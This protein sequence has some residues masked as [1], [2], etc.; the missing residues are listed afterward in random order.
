MAILAAV[1]LAA[2]LP[3]RGATLTTLVEFNGS[4][5]APKGSHPHG[6]LVLGLDGHFYG[7]TAGGGRNQVGT[8]F[9]MS[10][11]GVVTTL[12]DFNSSTA[13]KGASPRGSLVQGTDGN[14][15]GMT[16]YGGANGVGTAFTMTPAGVVTTLVEFNSSTA[17]K[18][19]Y[20]EGSLVQGTDGSF[21]GMTYEGGVH[22][23]GT[24]F[25]MTPAGVVTTLVEFN[26]HTA[27]KGRNPMGS[28]VLGTDG[29]FYGL[30]SEGG[31][32]GWG[33][34][35]QMTSTGVLTTLV[36]F[37]YKTAPKGLLPMGSLVLGTGGNFYGMTNAGG[38]N[39]FGTV[40]EMTPAGVLTT[41]VEFN[42]TSAPKG[43]SPRGTLVL[44]TDGNFYGT[45]GQGGA[46]NHG[47]A[48]KMTP[49]GVLTTLVEFNEFTA[50]KGRY[51]VG[52]LVQGADGEFYGM[53]SAGGSGV[54]PGG[55]GTAFK[56]DTGLA[57]VPVITLSSLT[58]LG[59]GPFQLTFP[60][61]DNLTWT[62]L[63]TSDLSQPLANWTVL[64]NAASIGGG[65]Y[66]FTDTDA[67]SHPRRFYLLRF[68]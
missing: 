66:Q 36:E 45:T 23:F 68:P 59:N 30:T 2:L 4:T 43:S 33:T 63:A 9:R 26:R 55:A 29:N 44:G 31:A 62:V 16:Q 13:P 32:N 28:L 3:A 34:A 60:N 19:A 6:S 8:V 22:N 17:P 54:L 65:V 18:G 25:R 20:P 37:N 40:F 21:Y 53:T 5:T 56:L 52:S 51:P 10:P 61:P 64:G 49:A 24:V 15:Y 50:P 48:F 1:L 27:P 46:N 47:T 7:M 39:N 41:L 12:V 67:N 58:K 57:A 42:E 11:A 14:F 38:A 35:F